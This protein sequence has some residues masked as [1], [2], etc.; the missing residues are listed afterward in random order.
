MMDSN[1]GLNLINDVDEEFC[2]QKKCVDALWKDVVCSA[3]KL[4]EAG[5]PL[6][7]MRR[8]K[9]QVILMPK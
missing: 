4:G 5:S 7:D 9:E 6:A 2:E 8:R 3:I 1:D